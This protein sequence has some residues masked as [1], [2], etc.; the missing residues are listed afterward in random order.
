MSHL[1]INLLQTHAEVQSNEDAD[2]DGLPL[3]A[4]LPWRSPTGTWICTL[5]VPI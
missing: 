1:I 3:P 2:A 5:I 4:M